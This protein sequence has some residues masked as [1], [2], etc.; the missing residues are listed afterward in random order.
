MYIRWDAIKVVLSSHPLPILLSFSLALFH[1]ISFFS[2]F[3]TF[4]FFRVSLLSLLVHVY[5]SVRILREV[6][7]ASPRYIYEE[8]LPL[9]VSM[10]SDATR[11]CP[12]RS[13]CARTHVWSDSSCARACSVYTRAYVPILRCVI[14]RIGKTR[15]DSHIYT[16]TG[17]TG[18]NYASREMSNCSPYHKIYNSARCGKHYVLSRSSSLPPGHS[19]FS[20]PVVPTVHPPTSPSPSSRSRPRFSP[21]RGRHDSQINSRGAPQSY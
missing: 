11:T 17:R 19:T 5:T 15:E 4:H 1:L 20:H 8:P 9:M 6:S 13:A 12:A 21:P 18:V 16:R 14:Q 3:S 2:A 10:R 7:F